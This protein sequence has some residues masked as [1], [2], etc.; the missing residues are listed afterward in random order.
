MAAQLADFKNT[1]QE[2]E[3]KIAALETEAK[4]K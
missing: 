1:K 3:N 2:I 4:G